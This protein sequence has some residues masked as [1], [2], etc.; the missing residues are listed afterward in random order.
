METTRYFTEQVLRK[1]SYLKFEHCVAVVK[2]PL[3]SEVQ[4][5]GRMRLW[6]RV[7][8]LGNRIL[9]VVLL[10]DGKTIHNAFLDRGFEV[11]SGKRGEE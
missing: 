2:N 5:D 1:R 7:P 6:G 8:E 4:A 3:K 9:R 11:S 10:E